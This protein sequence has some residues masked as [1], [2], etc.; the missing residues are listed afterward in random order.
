M[1]AAAPNCRFISEYRALLT[2]NDGDIIANGTFN[3]SNVR[4]M[5][6]EHL[7]PFTIYNISV[8]AINDEGYNTT[9]IYSLVTLETGKGIYY[10]C[11][12]GECLTYIMIVGVSH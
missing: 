2:S 3:S 9:S 8:M 4:E 6:V 12:E 11:R 10:F 5:T 7:Q 1:Q